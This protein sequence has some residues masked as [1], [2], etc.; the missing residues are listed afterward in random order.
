MLKLITRQPNKML[1]LLRSLKQSGKE[2]VL[3]GAGV[4]GANCYKVL[5]DNDIPVKCFCDDNVNKQKFGFCGEQVISPTELSPALMGGG[6][7]A[8]LI[9]SYNPLKLV[10]RLK[11]IDERLADYVVWSD[12]Y[13]WED[14]LDYYSYYQEHEA[15]ISEVYA[16]LEDE[17]SKRVLTNLL[18]YKISRDPRLIKQI[19]DSSVEEQYFD[20]DIVRYSNGEVFVDMGAYIG[21]TVEEFVKNADRQDRTYKKIYAFEPDVDNFKML[22]NNT[23]KY[24]NVECINGGVYSETTV[25]RFSSG[26]NWTSAISTEGNIEVPVFALDDRIKEPVTFIKADIEGAEMSAIEGAKNLIAEC[27]PRVAFCVYHRKDDIFNI[28]LAFKKLNPN[29]KFY[30]RHYRQ[31]AV[32]TV[33]YAIDNG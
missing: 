5:R 30:M 18:N 24:G 31:I 14:G 28:P 15:E 9:T 21:D 32:E 13:L 7:T 4:C 16:L 11:N 26:G 33:L 3:F 25:L 1:G 2:V 19:D 23:S 8:V 22:V 29:Y 12:F 17:K 27:R 10:E 20:R 6:C